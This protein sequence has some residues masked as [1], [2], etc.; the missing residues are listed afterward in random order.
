MDAMLEK[1]SLLKRMDQLLQKWEHSEK[2]TNL[3]EKKGIGTN[4]REHHVGLVAA[5]QEESSMGEKSPQQQGVTTDS[6]PEEIP[7]PSLL[8]ET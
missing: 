4:L 3:E 8:P 2:V 7:H 6:I 1:Q 5:P